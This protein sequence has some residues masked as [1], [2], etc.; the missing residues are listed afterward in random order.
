MRASVKGI[1]GIKGKRSDWGKGTLGF[2]K[3]KIRVLL[4]EKRGGH[5]YMVIS[6]ESSGKC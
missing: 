6:A 5:K 1:V 2:N 4:E 3:K